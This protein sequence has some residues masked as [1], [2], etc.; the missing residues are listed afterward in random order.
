MVRTSYKPRALE[1]TSGLDSFTAFTIVRLMRDMAHAGKAV[2]AIV[3]QPS[4]DIFNQ[5]DKIYLLGG[6]REAYQ[7]PSQ[8]YIYL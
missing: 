5:F 1:L 7:V 3:Q 6:G 2:M 8:C 4:T